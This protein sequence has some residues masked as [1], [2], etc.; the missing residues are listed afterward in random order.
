[1]FDDLIRD[2]TE[3]EAGGR[4]EAKAAARG[5]LL[6]AAESEGQR[7]PRRRSRFGSRGLA[8]VIALLVVPAGVAVATE[9][10]REGPS[11]SASDCPEFLAGLEERGLSLEGIR[12]ADCPAG[13]ELDQLLAAMA[14][15][16]ERRSEM[17][18]DGEPKVLGHQVVGFGRSS[19]RQP[20]SIVGIA[21]E[22]QTESGR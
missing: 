7:S 10:G 16:D 18:T 22:G 4:A 6:A 19:D 3:P 21:G 13:P 20:W 11:L 8:V 14:T 5:R 9:L 15:L 17:D 12:L 1:M 2:V